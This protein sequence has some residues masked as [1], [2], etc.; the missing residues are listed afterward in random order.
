MI[1]PAGHDIGRR[2]VFYGKFGDQLLPAYGT[3]AGFN[4]Q[5]AFV[6][7][8]ED[9]NPAAV[10]FEDLYW[11]EPKRAPP[12]QPAEPDHMRDETRGQQSFE[13]RPTG[14]EMGT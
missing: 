6:R 10:L 4:Q 5:Q 9:S 8:G 3:L 11:A 2:V 12:L 1:D 13:F 7:Y 14:V